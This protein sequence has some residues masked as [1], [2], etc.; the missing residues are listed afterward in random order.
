VSYRGHSGFRP[1]RWWGLSSRDDDAPR[2]ADTVALFEAGLKLL[3]GAGFMV[4]Q[5][6]PADPISG[7]DDDDDESKKD[8]GMDEKDEEPFK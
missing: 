1:G 6:L 3:S 7:D 4:A 5:K 2:A 8:E